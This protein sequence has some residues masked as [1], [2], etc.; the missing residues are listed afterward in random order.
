MSSLE[1]RHDSLLGIGLYTVRD[2]SRLTGVHAPRIRRWL[3]GYP[4]R[5]ALEVK[6]QNALWRPEVP[7][8]NE[9]V[10]LSFNDLLEIRFVGA[11]RGLGFS[12]QKIRRA[13]SELG[14]IAETAYPFSHRKVVTDGAYLFAQLKNEEGKPLFVFE[15]GE[16]NYPEL[17]GRILHTIGGRLAEAYS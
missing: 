14:R 3:L 4:Y 16:M 8:M 10:A 5:T 12:I 2:A 1:Q 15:L 7:R 17:S 6:Q 11:F 9:T 13:I